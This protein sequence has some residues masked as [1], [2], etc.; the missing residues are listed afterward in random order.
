MILAHLPVDRSFEPN[1]L[2][3]SRGFYG[4]LLPRF[5]REVDLTRSGTRCRRLVEGC[6]R[7]DLLGPHRTLSVERLHIAGDA[8]LVD[9]FWRP[10]APGPT[11]LQRL[12]AYLA[13]PPL[14]T[15]ALS[16]LRVANRRD[17]LPQHQ[18]LVHVFVPDFG[19]EWAPSA[20]AFDD[21]IAW[22]VDILPRLGVLELEGSAGEVVGRCNPPVD[23][24][25][26][27]SAAVGGE[28]AVHMLVLSLAA[29]ARKTRTYR[30]CP[31]VETIR[32]SSFDMPYNGFY[33]AA[34]CRPPSFTAFGS[35]TGAFPSP[36]STRAPST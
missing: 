16:Y 24:L 3:V 31:Y 17:V 6:E 1:L 23:F 18:R 10:T 14:S 9:W 4:K 13:R 5:Y 29:L 8:D 34:R 12:R 35:E 20:L 33:D 25:N 15:A 19:W 27:P 30:A 7:F 28:R 11:F 32:L 26:E 22:L 21:V 36:D 2:R